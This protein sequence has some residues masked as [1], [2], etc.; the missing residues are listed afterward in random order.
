[1]NGTGFREWFKV[2]T[3]D[4][5][6]SAGSWLEEQVYK[7]KHEFTGTEGCLE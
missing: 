1:M 6:N 3:F 2:S 5:L 7:L 4:L